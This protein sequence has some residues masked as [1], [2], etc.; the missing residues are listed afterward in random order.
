MTHLFQVMAFVVMEPTDGVEPRAI[1]EEKNKVLPLH[2]AG[3]VFKTWCAGNSPAT[4]TSKCGPRFDTETFVALKVGIDNWRWAGVPIYLRTGK[5]L[6]EGMRIISIAFKEAPRSM[7]P[8]RLRR[9][10]SGTRPPH[11]RPGRQLQ[12]S[13]R[14]T[15][16]ARPRDETRQA[17]DCSSPRRRSTRPMTC[18]RPTSG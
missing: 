10:L 14:S 18:S 2:V 6:A 16:S 7:F 17:V 3:Q 15:E 11:V 5:R 12:V 4:A 1:S 8:V 9:R 13:C